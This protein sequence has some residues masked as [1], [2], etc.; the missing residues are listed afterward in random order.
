MHYGYSDLIN[1]QS[2]NL[3]KLFVD[4]RIRYFIINIFLRKAEIFDVQNSLL[5]MYIMHRVSDVG[6]V[7]PSVNN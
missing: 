3:W 1:F 5:H 2:K 4:F 7:S 6:A